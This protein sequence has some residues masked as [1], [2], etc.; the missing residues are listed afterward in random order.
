MGWIY[1]RRR[2]SPA[3]FVIS[4]F[5][6]I[7]FAACSGE[8]VI[9]VESDA[10]DRS[11]DINSDSSGDRESTS[12]ADVSLGDISCGIVSNEEI[13]SVVGVGNAE[14]AVIAT[15]S[16][17]GENLH[18]GWSSRGS[19][20]VPNRTNLGLSDALVTVTLMPISA[21]DTLS[22]HKFVEEISI[23][24]DPD[25]ALP[26]YGEGAFRTGFGALMRISGDY[27]MEVMVILD[28]TDD[29]L[30]AAKALSELVDSR[31]GSG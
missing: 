23:E 1:L 6:V 13:I 29:D 14:Q 27:V 4:L 25:A 17:N 24:N 31:L 10:S 20:D 9:V 15:G 5:A 21:P 18:C 30:A 11:G 12:N 2:L 16:V 28:R 8:T 7:G 3:I 26:E 22:N 19:R